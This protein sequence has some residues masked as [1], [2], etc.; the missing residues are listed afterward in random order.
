MYKYVFC[1]HTI[2]CPKLSLCCASK[3]KIEGMTRSLPVVHELGDPGHIVK[4]VAPGPT[5][6]D[7]LDNVLK[8]IVDRQLK[9]TAVEKSVGT[10]EDIARVVA[11]PYSAGCELPSVV[12][13][14]FQDR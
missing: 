7:M 1:Q 2:L 5:E 14:G 8:D 4:A 13:F 11:W 6:S 10:A 3:A 9:M 12:V